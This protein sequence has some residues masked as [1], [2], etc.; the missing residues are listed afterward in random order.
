VDS[1]GNANTG[2]ATVRVYDTN[3]NLLVS[4]CAEIAGTRFEL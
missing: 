3:G 1:T 2:S 4:L